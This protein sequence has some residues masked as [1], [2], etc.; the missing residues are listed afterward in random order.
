MQVT[1]NIAKGIGVARDNSQMY[2]M[3]AK[4]MMGIIIILNMSNTDSL[5]GLQ[6]YRVY[7]KVDPFKFKL[8]I[9]YYIF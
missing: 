4:R 8:A 2:I 9:L 1:S 6:I 5:M 7:K 3:S